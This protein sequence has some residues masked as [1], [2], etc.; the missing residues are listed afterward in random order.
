MRVRYVNQQDESDPMNR[1][2][3]AGIDKLAELLEKRRNNAPFIAELSADNGFHLMLGI[4]TRV[5]WAQYSRID[6]ELPYLVAIPPQQRVKNRYV[7]FLMN[8]TPTAIPGCF[9]LSFDE[10]KQIALHFLETGERSAA[11]TWEAI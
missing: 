4:G 5:G 11:F 3:V 9:I 6:G 1:T 2:I 10:A 8:N 7:E